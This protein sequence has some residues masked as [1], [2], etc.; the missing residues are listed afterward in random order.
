MVSQLTQALENLLGGLPRLPNSTRMWLR[1]DSRDCQ[2]DHQTQQPW[3]L[4]SEH[5]RDNTACPNE[6]QPKHAASSF[7]PLIKNLYSELS[8]I[9]SVY[10][11]WLPFI[12]LLVGF[13]AEAADKNTEPR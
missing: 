2:D 6:R 12:L 1:G 11:T 3:A 9:F 10:Y 5:S 4:S 13:P 8:G 7:V